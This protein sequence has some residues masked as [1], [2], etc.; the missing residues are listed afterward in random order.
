MRLSSVAALALFAVLCVACREGFDF[1]ECR[2]FNRDD[3]DRAPPWPATEDVRASNDG[4]VIVVA[5]L[6]YV[7]DDRCAVPFEVTVTVD[8][9]QGDATAEAAAASIVVYT[10]SLDERYQIDNDEPIGISESAEGVQLVLRM[11]DRNYIGGRSRFVH[12]QDAA[13]NG[14]QMFCAHTF[15]RSAAAAPEVPEGP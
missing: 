1:T 7:D 3:V 2:P 9:P 11:C 12:L 4:P 13:G 8:D 14:S 6:E 10:G 15:A 5:D